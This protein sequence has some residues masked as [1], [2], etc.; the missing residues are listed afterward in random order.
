M[1]RK[2]GWRL[3][4]TVVVAAASAGIIVGISLLAWLDNTQYTRFAYVLRLLLF[5]APMVLVQVLQFKLPWAV[6]G[7][8]VSGVTLAGTFGVA[9][10]VSG[11]F[12]EFEAML[13][14]VMC[15]VF[16]SFLVR[17][18]VLWPNAPGN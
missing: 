17:V 11:R 3:L 18:Q 6:G 7:A 12:T 2:S 13:M 16:V 15:G 8:I 10:A 9:G 14:L 1:Q 5:V 4:G